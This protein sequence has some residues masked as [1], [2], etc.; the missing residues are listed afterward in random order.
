[1]PAAKVLRVFIVDDDEN[2][3]TAL[4]ALVE[5]DGMTVAGTAAN[6]AEAV[7]GVKASKADV[8]TMDLDMPIM[9][10]VEATKR[11]AP[12]GIPIVIVSGSESSDRVG[13]AIAAGAV[14]SIVK[15]K[16]PDALLPLLRAVAAPSSKR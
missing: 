11:L 2:Y 8:I 5:S 1:M 13:L 14:G 10:G 16:V 15:A 3:R 6:G 7:A 4:R 9:D 12:L